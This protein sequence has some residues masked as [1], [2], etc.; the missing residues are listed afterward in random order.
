M[1][2]LNSVIDLV[3]PGTASG[4]QNLYLKS[5]NRILRQLESYTSKYSW[6]ELEQY[7]SQLL[8]KIQNLSAQ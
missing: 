2:M 1:K 5:I 6:P 7:K 4:Q 8:S 3:E